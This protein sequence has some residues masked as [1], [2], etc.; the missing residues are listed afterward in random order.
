M[1]TLNAPSR[2]A[3]VLA[4]LLDRLDASRVPVDPHQ[5]RSVAARLASLLADPDTD[6]APLLAHSPAAALLYENQ[7][8]AHAGLCRA[9]LAHAAAAELAARQAIAAVR[10]PPPA[11]S[12][13]RAT[14]A[15]S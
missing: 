14:G 15:S 9:P 5:Y 8:Y 13:A 11:G 10:Q 4:Q 7:R 3:Q 2:A 6:W 12:A 1:N